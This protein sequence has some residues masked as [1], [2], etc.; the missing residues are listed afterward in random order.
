VAHG[1]SLKMVEQICWFADKKRPSDHLERPSAVADFV[2][3]TNGPAYEPVQ[4]ASIKRVHEL[5]GQE[6]AGARR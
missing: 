1:L 6:R 2:G 4:P 3:A 5:I